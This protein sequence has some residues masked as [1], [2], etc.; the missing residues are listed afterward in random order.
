MKIELFGYTPSAVTLACCLLLFGCDSPGDVGSSEASSSPNGKYTY[1][2]SGGVESVVTVSGARWSSTLKLCDFCD[3][4]YESG[5]VKNGK[6][7]DSSGFMEVGSISGEKL[8]MR[9]AS[10]NI[11]H[12]K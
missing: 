4:D 2:E 7:F 3:K 12:R 5:V 8:V 1:T 6:L 10:G 11:T 9:T